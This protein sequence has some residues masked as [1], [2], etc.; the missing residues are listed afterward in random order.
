MFIDTHAHLTFPEFEGDLKEVLQRAKKAGVEKIICVGCDLKSD[1]AVLKLADK[2]GFIYATLG[3]HPYE[4]EKV[5]KELMKKWME[6]IRNNKKVVAIGE[7][8]LDYFK[9][10]V[11]KD[12]Q[13]EA[14]RLQLNIAEMFDLPVIVHNREADEESLEVLKEYRVRAV[15]HCYGSNLEFAQKVWKAG[16]MTSFT[17]IITYPNTANL[18][19]VVKACPLDKFMVETDCPYLAPQV[20]R[21]KRNEPGYVAEVAEKIAEIKELLPEKIAEISTKNASGFFKI[22]L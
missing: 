13:K 2:Y 16:Y 9:G 6:I 12:I 21:G 19:E 18:R 15:F 20:N 5:D 7:C 14:F 4:A 11:P 10:K 17:G 3:M 22:E 1:D 8:G